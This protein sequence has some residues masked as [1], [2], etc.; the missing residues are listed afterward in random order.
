[1]HDTDIDADRDQ[2]VDRRARPRTDE[3]QRAHHDAIYTLARAAELHDEDT[4]NHVIRIRLIVE[5]LAKRMGFSGADAAALGHDAMLHDVGKLTTPHEVLKK[6]G[7]LTDGERGIMESHTIQGERLLSRRP[8]MSRAARIA[9]SHHECWDG[10]GYPD[11]R[12]GAEIPLEARITAV[13]DVL[14]ALVADRCYKQ[15]WSYREAVEEVCAMA[16]TKLDPDVIEA[17]RRCDAA[18]ELEGIFRPAAYWNEKSEDGEG[19]R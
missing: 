13:A 3:A 10:S 2:S 19:E 18:G 16:G 8:T 9:R 11:G 17:L 5:R 4:G 15:S 14:E 1:M 7:A 6:P 12:K